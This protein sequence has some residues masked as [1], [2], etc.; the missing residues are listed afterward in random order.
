MYLSLEDEQLTSWGFVCVPPFSSLFNPNIDT[1]SLGSFSG[2]SSNLMQFLV[3]QERL[4]LCSI[5]FI[6]CSLCADKIRNF[7]S[8]FLYDFCP[9]FR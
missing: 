4:L 7:L 6:M 1:F 5:T 9:L 8:E 3:S 2:N